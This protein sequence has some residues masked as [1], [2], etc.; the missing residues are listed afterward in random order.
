MNKKRILIIVLILLFVAILGVAFA[1]FNVKDSAGIDSANDA[2]KMIRAIYKNLEAEL[3]SLETEM[4]DV[5]DVSLV[6]SY[7]GLNSNENIKYMVISEPLMTSQAYSLVI[8]KVKNNSLIEK[9]KQEIVDNIDMRK[10]ICVS[11]EKLYVTNHDD[12]IFLVM[13]S[14][15]LATPVYNEFKKYV[16]NE[17][18]KELEKTNSEEDIDLPPEMT[19]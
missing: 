9:M 18:G 19:V 8:I 14:D 16:N 17:I 1:K 4:V 2:K 11:A 3:P 5:N 6:T 7:T 13:S 12:L 10:W 15:D